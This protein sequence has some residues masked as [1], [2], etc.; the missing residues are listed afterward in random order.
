M[1]KFVKVPIFPITQYLTAK[2]RENFP[3]PMKPVNF[4]FRDDEIH[5][6]KV[7][8]CDRGVSRKVGGRG[9]WFECRVSW[10]NNDVERTQNSILWFDDF[11]LEWFVEV[12]ES[13]APV[14]WD[15]ARQLSDI[16]D[17]YDE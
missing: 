3:A 11:L 6:E 12:K 9:F 10:C 7:L 13:R 15:K 8:R 1:E 2:E 17:F 5:V 4:K 14:D 16:G